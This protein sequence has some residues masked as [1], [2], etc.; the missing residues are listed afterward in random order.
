MKTK[1]V[2]K[3]ATVLL[4]IADIIYLIADKAL[5]LN[6]IDNY[7]HGIIAMVVVILLRVFKTDSAVTLDPSKDNL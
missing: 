4:A 2:L 3:S 6:Y 1:F 7:W 5:E